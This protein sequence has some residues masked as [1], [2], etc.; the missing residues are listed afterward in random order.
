M[1]T[2]YVGILIHLPYTYIV[3][4]IYVYCTVTVGWIEGGVGVREA[5]ARIFIGSRLRAPP[6]TGNLHILCLTEVA[7]RF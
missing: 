1:D 4:W 7:G 3:L 5:A 6:L 2:M